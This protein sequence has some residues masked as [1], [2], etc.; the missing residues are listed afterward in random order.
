M[1]TT[2][3][4]GTSPISRRAWLARWLLVAA[5]APV[6]GVMLTTP[7]QATKKTKQ[8]IKQR[9]AVYKDWCDKGGGTAMVTTR[10]GG[11]TVT[12]TGS[13]SGDWSC[14]VT[15]QQ[16]RCFGTGAPPSSAPVTDPATPPTGNEQPS[17]SSQ[18][19]GG[20]GVTPGGGNE[21]PN[22]P[23]DADG[24]GQQAGG[25]AGVDPGGSADHPGAGDGTSDGGGAVLRSDHRGNRTTLRT[26]IS[27]VRARRASSLYA[28]TAVTV[29]CSDG[30]PG[31]RRRI[32]NTVLPVA[33]LN[34]VTDEGLVARCDAALCGN[35]TALDDR[36]SRHQ[37]G[38]VGL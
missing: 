12:C 11:T 14:T 3:A 1:P 25:S 29:A 30:S 8:Q 9:A 32:P 16:D 28:M 23:G 13:E 31:R 27:T 5:A 6:V 20:T 2:P 26:I 15:S 7:A 17:D 37:G 36:P 38:V 18:A 33:D 24:G 22:D 19:S 35:S 10:P 21:Q 4:A 34:L